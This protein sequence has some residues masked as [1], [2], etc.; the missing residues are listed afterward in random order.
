MKANKISITSDALN[1]LF[2]YEPETGRL[3]WRE[4]GS[5]RKIGRAAGSTNKKGYKSV[6]IHGSSYLAHRIIWLMVYGEI[7]QD[8]E[9][10]HKDS[11]PSNNRLDNLRLVTSQGNQWNRR[12]A[13]GY[14]WHKSDKKWRAQIKLDMNIIQL[15]QFATEHE[16]RNAYLEA[17]AKYHQIKEN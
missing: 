10:D 15:G 8:L 5:G 11:D 1:E 16:A 6:K 17:K 13:K 9:I 7:R 12:T 14:H 3:F 2:R 4:N